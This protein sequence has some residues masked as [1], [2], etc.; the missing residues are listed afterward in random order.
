[1][2]LSVILEELIGTLTRLCSSCTRRNLAI[3]FEDGIPSGTILEFKLYLLETRMSCHRTAVYVL[4]K[5]VQNSCIV[6]NN[7]MRELPGYAK[8]MRIGKF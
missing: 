4:R 8:I 2:S 6:L 7:N 1:M 5:G 3:S